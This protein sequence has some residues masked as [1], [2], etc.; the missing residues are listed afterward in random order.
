MANTGNN[1]TKLSTLQP[2]NNADSSDQVVAFS[3]VSNNIDVLI[4]VG[5]LYSNSLLTA[6][7]II[8][9]QANTPS[10]SNSYSNNIP[11]TVWSDGN[12]IYVATTANNIVRAALTSF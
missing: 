3:A 10:H 5:N 1:S 7:Q 6:N 9:L 4:P 12:F 11:K 8:I 2:K